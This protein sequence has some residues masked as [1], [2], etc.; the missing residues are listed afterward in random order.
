MRRLK[1]ELTD[2]RK[3]IKFLKQTGG[4]AEKAEKQKIQAELD[5]LK[6]RHTELENRF[7]KESEAWAED[8]KSLLVDIA[9]RDSEI[10]A[11]RQQV[12]DLQAQLKNKGKPGKGSRP[13][14]K[15]S[16]KT[17]TDDHGIE[18]ILIEPGSF[19]M[20]DKSINRAKPVHRVEITKPFYLGKYPVT[21][22]EWKAI[23]GRSPSSF[24][25][26]RNPVEQVS[27]N[28]VQ[29]LLKK[30]SNGQNVYHM[31]TEAQWEYAC[32]AGTSTAYSFG[33]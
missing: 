32:R 31:P 24:K 2:A 6:Q 29:D 17:L 14:V 13:S 10:G 7:T 1:D 9:A 27:W 33:K 21:Q 23:T 4:A 19:M 18:F 5:G 15:A 25:G 12:A 30:M 3:E 26:E 16:A 11:F 8:R 22:A 28:D 20:G